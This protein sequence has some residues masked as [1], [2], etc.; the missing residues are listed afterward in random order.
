M[1]LNNDRA[2]I[3][4]TVSALVNKYTIPFQY[5]KSSEILVRLVDVDKKVSVLSLGVDYSISSCI[6]GEGYL[7]R[8]SSWGDNV[9]LIITRNVSL[10][11]ETVYYNG[12]EINAK[13]I[14][15]DFDKTVA[16]VI[17]INEQLKRT[18]KLSISE[19]ETDLTLPLSEFRRDGLLG[20]DETGKNL[21]ITKGADVQKLLDIIEENRKLMVA[22]RDETNQLANNIKT[23]YVEVVG[24][25]EDAVYII[26]HNLNTMDID[27]SIWSNLEPYV[28]QK[29]CEIEVINEN[30]IYLTFPEPIINDSMRVVVTA[31]TTATAL[32]LNSYVHIAWA[33]SSDGVENF[34]LSNNG[35]YLG[36][37]TDH[38]EEGSI[39]PS[40]YIW[41]NIKGEKGEQ[42]LK[43]DN[44]EDNISVQIYSSNGNLFKAGKVETVLTAYVFKGS[45]DI[46]NE[47]NAENFRWI[48]NSQD[49][50]LNDEIWNTSSKAIGVKTITISDED[51]IGRTIFNCE[52]TI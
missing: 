31:T 15:R 44:G 1:S 34:S 49:T 8:L 38:F 5:W 18:L 12:Q 28:L 51:T 33:T 4:Y 42:G 40:K 39:D 43:G 35:T 19:E 25:G 23:E 46:T 22:I 52:V 47:I 37:Y 48:R 6:N 7:T 20:F 41:T 36:I 13:V 45:L 17:Q 2:E 30:T 29:N 10:T 14:E 32:G 3:K 50:A 9:T 21:V 24:N 27:V 16:R 26:E 11:Q